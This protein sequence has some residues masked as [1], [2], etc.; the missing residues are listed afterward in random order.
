MQACLT[1]SRAQGDSAFNSPA[2]LMRYLKAGAMQAAQYWERLRATYE[3]GLPGTGLQ[4]LFFCRAWPRQ[5]GSQCA[6]QWVP[7]AVRFC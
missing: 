3:V 1:P 5:S 2:Q 7:E 6:Q 4:Q